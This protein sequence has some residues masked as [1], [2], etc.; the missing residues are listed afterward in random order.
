MTPPSAV[1]SYDLHLEHHYTP[2]LICPVPRHQCHWFKLRWPLCTTS[3]L[4]SRHGQPSSSGRPSSIAGRCL[5]C[6]EAADASDAQ[7]L[8]NTWEAY[9]R[10]EMQVRGYSTSSGCIEKA[11]GRCADVERALVLTCLQL[12]LSIGASNEQSRTQTILRIVHGS[13]RCPATPILLPERLPSR[14]PP[15]R[16]VRACSICR[17]HHTSII[18]DDN[19]GHG[20]HVN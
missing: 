15:G 16:F 13:I 7:V 10:F 4:L 1:A 5:D 8:G 14:Q 3:Q 17:Q 12:H 19:G 6:S 2:S 11:C 9:G 18:P 20:V